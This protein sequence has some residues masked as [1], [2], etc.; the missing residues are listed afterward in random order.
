MKPI[1][2]NK[3][4]GVL[5]NITNKVK[6]QKNVD[7]EKELTKDQ[8]ALSKLDIEKQGWVAELLDVVT[9]KEAKGPGKT[10][11]AVIRDRKDKWG[12]NEAGD[13]GKVVD[14]YDTNGNSQKDQGK[15]PDL[16]GNGGK[17]GPMHDGFVSE[18]K[19]TLAYKRALGVATT[20]QM[21]T[22]AEYPGL[23]DPWKDFQRYMVAVRSGSNE[24]FGVTFRK[25][26]AFVPRTRK[27]VLQLIENLQESSKNHGKAPVKPVDLN[28]SKGDKGDIKIGGKGDT[29]FP[30]FDSL[31]DLLDYLGVE[32]IWQTMALVILERNGARWTCISQYPC[33]LEGE[34]WA[35]ANRVAGRRWSGRISTPRGVT[36]TLPVPCWTPS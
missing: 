2:H 11:E 29:K 12:D 1:D 17:K 9:G 4:G 10:A 21:Y 5:N 34:G 7:F 3:Y 13:Y 31:A 23:R 14:Q 18:E 25:T 28:S 33:D 15:G 32:A 26:A 35:P 6:S 36:L 30:D 8:K 20:Y 27:E 24:G 16:G 19:Q 22:K